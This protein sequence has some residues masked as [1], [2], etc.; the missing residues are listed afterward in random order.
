VFRRGAEAQVQQ[1]AVWKHLQ[2]VAVVS[3]P[4]T[5]EVSRVFQH[6]AETLEQQLVVAHLQSVAAVRLLLVVGV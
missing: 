6:G 3:L 4:M 5:V 1:V 2:S